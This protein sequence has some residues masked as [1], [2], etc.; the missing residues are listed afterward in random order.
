M[1]T[2]SLTDMQKKLLEV[3]KYTIDFFEKHNIKYIV[4]GGT[5]L[6]AVRHKGFIPWDDDIDLYL[7]RDDYEK[8]KKLKAEIQN[9]GYYLQSLA[10]EN[11]YLPFMKIINPRTTIWEK[12]KFEFL[13]GV[14]VDIFPMD[15]FLI[16]DGLLKNRQKKA[17]RLFRRYQSCVQKKS[18]KYLLK[19]AYS[20]RWITFFILI[21]SK[22]CPQVKE[23]YLRRFSDFVRKCA[24]NQGEYCSLLTAKG[25]MF[26]CSWFDNTI[27]GEFEDLKLQIPAGY[28]SYLST[29]YGDYMTPPPENKRVSVHNYL[30]VDLNE[31]LSMQEVKAKIQ[32]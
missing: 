25:K 6:G 3:F 10:D 28:N 4:C 27:N 14:F 19:A 11:Y 12:A 24:D 9:D 18:L 2:E 17:R 1:M 13:S 26:A 23:K 22:F 15:K 5:L 16:D 31:R 20:F 8:L 21:Q 30:F 29:L 7:Y 32:K